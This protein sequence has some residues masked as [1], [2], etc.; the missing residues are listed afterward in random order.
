MINPILKFFF[1]SP[2]S[3]LEIFIFGYYLSMTVVN[4][5]TIIINPMIDRIN[6]MTNIINSML[7]N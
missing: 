4:I 1:M 3:D 2:Y 7:N 6:S 5:K